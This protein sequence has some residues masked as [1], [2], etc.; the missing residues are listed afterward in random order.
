MFLNCEHNMFTLVVIDTSSSGTRTTLKGNEANLIFEADEA[1]GVMEYRS[2][3]VKGYFNRS[4]DNRTEDSKVLSCYNYI[5]SPFVQT[6]KNMQGIR[7]FILMVFLLLSTTSSRAVKVA[8]VAATTTSTT[9]H[10]WVEH[11]RN[12]TKCSGI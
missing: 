10:N 1:N 5:T 2:I 9:N 11:N 7:Y 6:M 3:I 12:Q 4:D 8:T